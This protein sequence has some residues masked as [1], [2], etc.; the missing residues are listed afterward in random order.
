MHRSAAVQSACVWQDSP[1]LPPPGLEFEL[2]LQAHTHTAI[3]SGAHTTS[4][5]CF[6]S[7]SPRPASDQNIP[8]DRALTGYLRPIDQDK[9][10]RQVDPREESNPLEAI[11]SAVSETTML[12]PT[13]NSA[14]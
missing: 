2:L 5:Q 3:A 13:S 14:S 8:K 1:D 10:E 12:D 7:A 11:E 9:P 6:T 4:R